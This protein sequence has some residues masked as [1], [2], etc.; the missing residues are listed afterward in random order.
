MGH[1]LD[2]TG[3]DGRISEVH[4]PRTSNSCKM[5]PFPI[6]DKNRGGVPEVDPDA[7]GLAFDDTLRTDAGTLMWAKNITSNSVCS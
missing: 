1:A 7:S 6:L 3:I 4:V 5:L 2:K